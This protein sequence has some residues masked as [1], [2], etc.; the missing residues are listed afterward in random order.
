MYTKAVQ[1]C[2]RLHGSSTS[3]DKVQYNTSQHEATCR[4]RTLPIS[5][6]MSI[7]SRAALLWAS[8]LG[9]SAS[10]RACSCCPRAVS[11]YANC[12]TL[13][14]SRQSMQLVRSTP[15]CSCT[16]CPCTLGSHAV[17]DKACAHHGLYSKTCAS[18]TCTPWSVLQHTCKLHGDTAGLY[19]KTL[20]I[21]QDTADTAS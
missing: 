13:V 10:P 11:P 2:W 14:R 12:A 21:L 15:C 20:Q 9:M 5:S 6:Y 19:F 7:S 3:T 16:C 1:Q 18:Y 17:S 8:M 4:E